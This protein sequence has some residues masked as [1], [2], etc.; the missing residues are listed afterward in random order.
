MLQIMFILNTRHVYGSSI[1]YHSKLTAVLKMCLLSFIFEHK[2]MKMN[3]KIV[4]DNVM[5]ILL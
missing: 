1:S 5:I 4:K 2:G 3:K